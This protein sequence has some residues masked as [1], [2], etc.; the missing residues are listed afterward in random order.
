MATAALV[1][2]VVSPGEE[3]WEKFDF[4]AARGVDEVLIADPEDREL[5]LFARAADGHERRNSSDVLGAS[6]AE[7]GAGLHWPPLR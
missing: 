5:T 7:L 4:Y 1:V 6:L 2:E 3:S